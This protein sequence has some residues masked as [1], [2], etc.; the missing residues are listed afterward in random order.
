MRHK[1][2]KSRVLVITLLGLMLGA[3]LTV[4][5]VQG[6]S[7]NEYKFS[8]KWSSKYGNLRSLA[9][10]SSGNVYVAS[11]ANHNIQKFSSNGTVLATWGLKGGA[12]GQL[13]YPE[14]IAVDG[15]GYVYVCDQNNHRI[16]KFTSSGEFVAKWGSKGSGDGQF[17]V[18]RSIAVDGF[19]NVYVADVLNLRI[20]K[21]TSDGQYL[22][23][24]GSE[25]TG[26]GQFTTSFFLAVDDG[27]NVYTTDEGSNRIQKFTP[28][29]EFVAKWGSTG[30]GDGQFNHP[31]GI[32]IDGSGSVF[33]VE[34][35]NARVQKFT[36]S[37]GFLSSWGKM[38]AVPDGQFRGPMGVA[39][40][41]SGNVYV[42]DTGNGRIQKFTPTLVTILK[43]KI[44][45]GAGNP[46]SGASVTSGTQPSGQTQLI[47]LTDVAGLTYFPGLKPGDYKL[48]TGKIGYIEGSQTIIV[49]ERKTA[50]IQIQMNLKPVLG[51][52]NVMVKDAG[53][54]PVSGVA[55]KS[56][57]QPNG[58]IAL[59]G[60][61]AA[62]GTALFSEL[63]LGSY[64]VQASKSGYVTGSTQGNAVAGSVSELSITLQ[65]QSSGGIPG[66]PYEALILG[67]LISGVYL[68]SVRRRQNPQ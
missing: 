49:A 16:Q 28:G 46:I 50:T 41:G 11:A 32:A 25:G 67:F 66:F 12:D 52:I 17:N 62:D 13:N 2:G 44:V 39:V 4:T 15:Y 42:A 60:I 23:K 14:G 53:G 5:Y 10:D 64:T 68:T 30:T 9:V 21:F 8:T 29:G 35:L 59:D 19:S 31:E 1:I 43:V 58:Q 3:A 26:D 6:Q 56:T 27:G 38:G 40:D 34:T 51:K 57:A 36:S 24:W 54:K 37:G 47:G 63:M 22:T 55:I 61:T 20:Q 33:V 48:Q 18:A 7:V 45:D 65:T